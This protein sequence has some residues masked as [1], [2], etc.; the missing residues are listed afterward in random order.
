MDLD[1]ILNVI[2]DNGYIGLFLWLWF[3]IFGVPI[4][5]EM[6]IMT[7][8][9]ASSMK[10]MNPFIA[11]FVTYAGITAAVTTSYI[12]GR[13]LGRRLLKVLQRRKRFAHTIESSLKLMEKHHAF[14]LSLSYF[15][16]GVRNFLPLLYGFSRLSFKTFA[17]FAYSGAL[18]W[19]AIVFTLGYL[20]GD[21]IGAIE[22][23]GKELF[24][25]AILTGI[26]GFIAIKIIRKKREKVK[27]FD[28]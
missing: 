2:E 26:A 10:A 16:P 4:P 27:V 12:L 17:V 20:F 25:M 23:Y 13:L 28:G 7:V 14:S 1:I 11:F 3:G 6:I 5:N 15:I 8:G 18:V 21:N 22:K 24:L 19:L 9:L